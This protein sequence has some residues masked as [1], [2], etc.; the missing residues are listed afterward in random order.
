VTLVRLSGIAAAAAREYLKEQLLDS[1]NDSYSFTLPGGAV[2]QEF[3][4][5]WRAAQAQGLSGEE[6]ALELRAIA[7][8]RVRTGIVI[9][10]LARRRGISGPDRED[11]VADALIAQ[12][13]IV[14]R[15]ATVEE[16]AELG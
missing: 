2:E 7:E 8:R 3:Q 4:G 12:A 9:A 11:R 16:V 13:Q 5:I 10:E 6:A 14:E 15:D 1:L